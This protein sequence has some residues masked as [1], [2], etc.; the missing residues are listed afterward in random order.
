MADSNK[1]TIKQ[2]AF[3][4]AYV[5]LGCGAQAYREAYDVGASTKI[6]S[7]W[8]AASALLANPKVSSR[9]AQLRNE[10]K[11]KNMI[12][13]EGLS[14]KLLTL[15]AKA[16]SDG[17]TGNAIKAIRELARLNGLAVEKRVHEG[18]LSFEVFGGITRGD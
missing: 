6:E 11:S 8:Q 5:R 4:Q 10:L 3:A 17:D 16:E 2:E 7:V 1:L 15:L 12:T 14:A 18:R 13:I 9:V